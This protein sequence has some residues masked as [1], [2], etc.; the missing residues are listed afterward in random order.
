MKIS[1]PRLL[2]AASLLAALACSSETPSFG[3]NPDATASTAS[4]DAGA[5]W[6]GTCDPVLQNCPAGQQ[7]TGGC[8]VSG[9]MTKAFT[10]AVP[11]AGATATQGQDCG[12]GCAR[13]HD[14]YVVPAPDGGMRSICRK[15][16]NVDADCPP[17]GRCGQEGLVCTAG[18]SAP[19]GRLCTI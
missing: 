6:P 4:F 7:C 11:A 10:C 19:I 18:D 12:A 8:N 15:Y 3:T 9:V 5:T 14:C 2:L 16:C 17:G 13:G 1:V